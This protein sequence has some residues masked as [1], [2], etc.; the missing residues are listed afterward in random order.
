MCMLV[1]DEN[2]I[3]EDFKTKKKGYCIKTYKFWLHHVPYSKGC[4]PIMKG[5]PILT[6]YVCLKILSV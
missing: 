5:I 3:A 1:L 4:I 6:C 2:V